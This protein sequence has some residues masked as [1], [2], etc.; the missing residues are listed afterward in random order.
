MVG[1]LWLR[2]DNAEQR[3]AQIEADLAEMRIAA[4]RSRTLAGE[5]RTELDI[6][7]ADWDDARAEAERVRAEAG[8][9]GMELEA[10]RAEARAAQEATQQAQDV[11]DRCAATPTTSSP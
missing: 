8:D 7:E 3:A 9:L 4:E 2:A 10:A 6:A 5:L 1:S 11:A